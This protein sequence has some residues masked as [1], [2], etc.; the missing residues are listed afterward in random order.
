MSTPRG[1]TTRRT[2]G[3]SKRQ[4]VGG[5]GGPSRWQIVFI[6][7][8]VAVV[9]SFVV[10]I[11]VA[12][13]S[14]GGGDPPADGVT[15]DATATSAPDDTPT[16]PDATPTEEASPTP[17][18]T[19]GEDGT[20]VVTCL[21][22]LAPLDKQ[23]RLLSSC[24]P[25]DLVALPGEIANGGGL[26]L[27]AEALEA[28][29]A[30]FKAAEADGFFLSVNSAYRSYDTQVATYNSAVAAFGREYADRTSAKPGHSEHQMGTTADLCARGL[31]LEDFVGSKEA[32]WVAANSWKFG[33]I[34]SY[35]EGKEAITGYA[36]EPWH[37]RYLGK[38]VAAQ[39]NASGVTLHEF[40]LR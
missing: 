36:Y 6:G 11:A 16:S 19:P 33:F 35:P 17:R 2:A 18:P 39:V 7:S 24:S 30:M 14:F 23:H 5:D 4:S 32:D 27:R 1:R 38:D 13:D 3:G 22:L 21:D 20:I 25:P 12:A 10:L 40:L 8:V 34:V 26:F 9:L 31:C 15:P 29:K 28:L 37:V